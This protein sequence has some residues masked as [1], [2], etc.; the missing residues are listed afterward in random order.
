MSI[1]IHIAQKLLLLSKGETIP[2]SSAKH[3]LIEEL[4]L[5]GIL[6]RNGRIKKTL[7]LQDNNALNIYLKNIYSITN[8]SDFIDLLQ[9]ENIT[10]NELVSVSSDSKLRKV[11]TFK[12]FLVNCFN[13][14]QGTLNNKQIIINPVEGTFQFIYDFEKFIPAPNI[15]I[16]GIENPEN[17]R[18]I[19]R[20]KYLFK[21]INPLFVCRYP[22]NQSKDLIKWL[23]VIPNNYLHFG[24]FDFAGIGIYINEFNKHLVDKSQFFIPEN[25][26]DLIKQHGN[27][28]RYNDQT[29]N[30][31]VEA[32]K[33]SSI[34]ELIDILHKYR[35]GL[36]QEILISDFKD[37]KRNNNE[38]IY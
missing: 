22:Q 4:V 10:R 14:I 18:H 2:S 26:D 37:Q 5:E 16:V 30:F 20:Q 32:I 35:K 12:G 13:P 3:F 8:L 28:N 23:K 24:D 1:P 29:T 11:R 36:D 27:K 9:K 6:E 17:F 19:G 21:N 31:N 34:I 33:E 38:E 25:I 15:T 7:R